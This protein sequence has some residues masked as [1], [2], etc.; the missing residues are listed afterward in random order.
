FAVLLWVAVVELVQAVL[1]GRRTGRADDI[2]V[3]GCAQGQDGAAEPGWAIRGRF[4]PD[5][6]AGIA[7]RIRRV[8]G[9]RLEHPERCLGIDDAARV[10][11]GHQVV[12]QVAE[13]GVESTAL[14]G[15]NP[16]LCDS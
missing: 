16:L 1:V 13:P 9:C 14:P 3:W 4:V 2:R 12:E 10:V 11:G 8:V 15:R 7:T 5:G 6:R